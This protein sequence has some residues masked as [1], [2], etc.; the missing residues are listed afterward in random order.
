MM[1]KYVFTYS[2]GGE[3]PQDAAERD[4]VMAAWTGWFDGLGSAVNDMGNPF[5]A[6][7]TV[8]SGGASDGT[9]SGVTGYSIVEAADQAAAVEIARGCPLLS[10][11]DGVVEVHEALAM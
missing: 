5:G 8:T 10:A 1:G 7:S 3:M 2:G 11:P 4:A 9:R 6:S